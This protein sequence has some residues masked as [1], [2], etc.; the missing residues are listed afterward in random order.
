MPCG[1]YLQQ[2]QYQIPLASNWILAKASRI[3]LKYVIYFANSLKN[4]WIF[5]HFPLDLW[6]LD[7]FPFV[8][9]ILHF[10]HIKG[11]SHV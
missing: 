11:E 2:E 6:I 4:I 5:M 8:T 1:L 10:F 7:P 9:R 3:L